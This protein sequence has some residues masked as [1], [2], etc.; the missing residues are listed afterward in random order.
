MKLRT[1][2][3]ILAGSLFMPW[4]AIAGDL[5]SITDHDT[6]ETRIVEDDPSRRQMLKSHSFTMKGDQEVF[7]YSAGFEQGTYVY[8]SDNSAYAL[9]PN[10]FVFDAKQS[11]DGATL[12]LILC[13][14]TSGSSGSW[15]RSLLVV[16]SLEVGGE[17]LLTASQVMDYTFLKNHAKGRR[18]EVEKLL[19]VNTYPEMEFG[20]AMDEHPKPPTKVLRFKQKWDVEA[21]KVLETDKGLFMNSSETPWLN[22]SP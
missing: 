2:F 15:Y 4:S 16:R 9:K 7:V 14:G 8:L 3:C 17:Y 1:V 18:F 21:E 12:I 5:L 13:E 22:P 20:M 6:G 19:D 10:H 11:E